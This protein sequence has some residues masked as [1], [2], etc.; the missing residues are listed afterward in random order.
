MFDKKVDLKKPIQVLRE[1]LRRVGVDID[2]ENKILRPNIYIIKRGE[3]W[4]IAHYKRLLMEKNEDVSLTADDLRL[5]NGVCGL[6]KSWDMIDIPT[7]LIY[8]RLYDV[9]V[10]KRKDRDNYTIEYKL[11]LKYLKVK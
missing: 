11:D 9:P 7:Y 10:I 8:S 2:E 3:F 1:T 4:Y 5:E 6:L